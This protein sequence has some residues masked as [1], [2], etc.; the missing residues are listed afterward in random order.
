MIIVGVSYQ[1]DVRWFNPS[2]LI[3]IESD[4]F[5]VS[6]DHITIMPEPENTLQ[7][8]SSHYYS[9]RKIDYVSVIP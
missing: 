7:N 2:H 1:Q 9:S 5:A 3:R 6:F 8:F 4:D